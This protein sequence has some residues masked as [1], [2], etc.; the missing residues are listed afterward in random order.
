MSA[1]PPWIDARIDDEELT[2]KLSQRHVVETMLEA[3]RPFFSVRQLQARLRPDVSTA[4]VRNRLNELREI[5]VVAAESYPDSITLY[6]LNHPESGWPLSPEGKRALR[7]RTPIDGLSLRAFLTLSDA[8]GIRTL[9]LSGFQLSLLLVVLGAALVPFGIDPAF[10]GDSGTIA[11]GLTLFAL[12]LGLYL[13]EALA[14]RLRTRR[15]DGPPGS[16]PRG[17]SGRG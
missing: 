3:D 9:V 14:R 12:C 15:T 17:R 5:D 7:E 8:Q 11:A 16:S 2:T 13:A 1:L 10:G 4:T 6:Y